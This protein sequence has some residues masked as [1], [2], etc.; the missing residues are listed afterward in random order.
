MSED[1]MQDKWEKYSIQV[2]K[3]VPYVQQDDHHE[4]CDNWDVNNRKC[5]RQY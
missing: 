5:N 1:M 2:K 4:K 3:R